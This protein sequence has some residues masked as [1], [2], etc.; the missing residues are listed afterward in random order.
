LFTEGG[1]EDDRAGARPSEAEAGREHVI[2]VRYRLDGG[3]TY[4]P[5]AGCEC[6]WEGA[7]RSSYLEAEMDG[8]WH[9]VESY[10]AKPGVANH[11]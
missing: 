6:G 3:P 4:R 10:Q 5:Y 1:S 8:R 2:L 11:S 9:R 7:L